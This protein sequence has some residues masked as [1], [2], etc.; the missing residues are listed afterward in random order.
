MNRFGKIALAGVA[1]LAASEAAFGETVVYQTN[2]ALRAGIIQQN[3][4]NAAYYGDVV[5]LAAPAPQLGKITIVFAYF[6]Y[7]AEIYTPTIQLD[8]FNIDS[9][10]LPVDSNT[11]DTLSYTPIATA[12]NTTATFTGSNYNGGG[13]SSGSDMKAS[14]DFSGQTA[15]ANLQ[16]FAFAY[17]DINPLG[18][19]APGDGFS[20]VLTTGGSTNTQGSTTLGYLDASPNNLLTTTF[21]NQG[22]YNL[23]AS[24]TVVPEPASLALLSLG[25]SLALRRRRTSW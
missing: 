4:N 8:L 17:R 6:T 12:F 23:E 18:N 14:F 25:S 19:V 10:G 1:G 9:N 11:N 24:I 13:K 7:D 3:G 16:N 2:D 21:T 5:Q 15:A 20:V 22:N